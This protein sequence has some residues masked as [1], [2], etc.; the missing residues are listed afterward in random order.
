MS[1]NAVFL[2]NGYEYRISVSI[3][4]LF[5]VVVFCFPFGYNNVPL[6]AMSDK[7]QRKDR[8]HES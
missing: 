4:T 2:T 6:A 1:I 5:I 8:G 7:F 3:W